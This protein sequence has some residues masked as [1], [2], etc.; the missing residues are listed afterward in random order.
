MRQIDAAY[1]VTKDSSQAGRFEEK[2]FAAR[3]AG[4]KIVLIGRP[5]EEGGR[6]FSDVLAHLEAGTGVRLTAGPGADT[7]RKRRV[8]LAGIGMGGP[9]GITLEVAEACRTADLVIGARRML[10][11]VELGGRDSSRSI[12]P[13]RSWRRSRPIPSI[14]RS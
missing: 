11:S 10:E 1:M 9:G 12:G 4:A 7:C 6:L 8:T 5:P 2:V 14:R 13:M 3:R